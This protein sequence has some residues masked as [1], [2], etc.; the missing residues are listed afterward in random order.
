MVLHRIFLNPQCKE[1]RRDLADPYQLH[2]TLCRAF[3]PPNRTISEGEVL[4][5]QEQEAKQTEK[6]CILVQS[7]LLPD[8]S[9]IG[10]KGWMDR[11]DPGINLQERLR[12]D[13]LKTGQRFRFRLRANPCVTRNRKRMGLFH[14]NDQEAWIIRKAALHGFSLIS[15]THADS[16][17][18]SAPAVQISQGQLLRGHQHSG[19]PVCVYAV[20]F[21]GFLSVTDPALFLLA[22]RKGV[23]HGKMMG[24]GLLSVVPIS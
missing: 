15:Q 9:A 11:A 22:I 8:W 7:S 12:F 1:V 10:V 20:L 2:S 14:V 13:S 23:G 4:W 16:N 6:P 19:N 17:A 21:E 24:L 18:G 5:R 3:N